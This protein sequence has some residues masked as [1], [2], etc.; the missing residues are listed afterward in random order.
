MKTLSLVLLSFV[1]ASF[2]GRQKW[3]PSVLNILLHSLQSGWREHIFLGSTKKVPRTDSYW[4]GSHS[5]LWNNHCNQGEW[6]PNC[7]TSLDH[8][9]S[10]GTQKFGPVWYVCTIWTKNG[11]K[12]IFPKD[13]VDRQETKKIRTTTTKKSK[14]VS[15]KDNIWMLICGKMLTNFTLLQFCCCVINLKFNGLKQQN[16]FYYSNSSRSWLDSARFSLGGCH[17]FVVIFWQGL[18]SSWR[19]THAWC[20]QLD[21]IWASLQHDGWVPERPSESC[22]AFH[23]LAH[24]PHSVIFAWFQGEWT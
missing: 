7:Q 9:P 19:H 16:S 11:R 2:L 3:L 21:F 13:V 5:H 20:C 12:V 14:D 23:D 1:L 22:V 15:L 18:K 17:V 10:P 24:K 4:L 8:L 6:I